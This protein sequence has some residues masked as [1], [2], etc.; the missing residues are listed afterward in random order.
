MM[1]RFAMLFVV[2][3]GTALIVSPSIANAAN[4]DISAAEITKIGIYPNLTPTSSIPVFLTDKAASP[5]FTGMMFYLHDSCGKEGLATLLTAFSLD[6]TV[7]VR[8]VG[9]GAGPAAGDYITVIY[10]NK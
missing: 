1:K 4:F 3:V 9:E 5:Q 2:L 6:K 10:V 7:L 8:I